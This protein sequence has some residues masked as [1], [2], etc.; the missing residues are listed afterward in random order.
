M[1]FSKDGG[2]TF[3]NQKVSDVSQITAPIPG[4]GMGYTGDYIGIAAHGGKAIAAWTDNRNGNWQIYTSEV[5]NKPTVNGVPAF[6]STA[7][8]TASNNPGGGTVTWS[9]SPSGIVT[10]SPSG[11][12]V[13]ATKVSQGFFTLT[14]SISR[15]YSDISPTLNLTTR[16]G[17]TSINTA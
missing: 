15:A 4:F 7:V 14:A 11:N 17:L 10:L 13:T 2:S 16:P 6:C 8:Y 3:S 12:Q 1:A 9:A 5:G